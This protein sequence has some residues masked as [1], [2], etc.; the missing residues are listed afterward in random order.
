MIATKT[1]RPPDTYDTPSSL[2]V[3]DPLSRRISD[4]VRQERDAVRRR[5]WSAAR[6]AAEERVALQTARHRAIARRLA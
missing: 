1:T 4:L 2:L 5:D 6:I 3:R